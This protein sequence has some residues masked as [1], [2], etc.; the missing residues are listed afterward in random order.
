MRRTLVTRTWLS[1]CSLSSLPPA[2]ANAQDAALVKKG[3][4]VYA[5]QKCSVCHAIAGKGSKTNPLDGVGAKLSA[6][7]IRAV[8]REPDRGDRQGQVDE[9]AAHAGEVRQAARGGYRRARRLHAE[10]EVADV[11]DRAARAR[12]P[13]ARDRGRRDHHGVGRGVHHPGDRGRWRGCSPTRTPAWWSSS[14]SRRVFVFGLL[15]IP[16]G[17][18]AAAAKAA[19]RSRRR[20]PNGRSSIFGAPASAGPP[21]SSRHSPPSTSSSFCSPGTA[22]CT[23]WSRQASADR[24]A[25][26]RCTR[27]SRP[28][29]TRRIPA[30]P[31]SQCHIGEGARA[32]VHSKLA[33]VRQLVQWSPATTRG[34]FR[35]DRR[36]AAGARNLRQLPPPTRGIGERDPRHPRICR[37]RS[38]HGDHDGAADARGRARTA[39][40]VGARDSLAR[41]SCR[42]RRVHGDRCRAADDPVRPRD[43]REGPGQGIRRQGH[44]AG[45]PR[46]G[47]RRG[48]WT[49][50][51]ATTPSRIPS[52]RQRSRP[53]I[54]PSPPGR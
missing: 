44:D 11:R 13:P 41:G 37:R 8:D 26:R 43:Q 16:A 6:A 1:S 36:S 5:A 12:A 30:S 15:L 52:R 20:S 50:S 25:T 49:A 39:H 28:G 22:A 24:R 53:S 48:R 32:L 38:Q 29:R 33:G 19:S 27:S 9:E 14:A 54:A 47:R 45:R 21:C 51:T 42:A 18:L 31:V 35:A 7:D 46:E 40:V 3:Q 10:S 17:M 23:R 34:R 2:I 4:E